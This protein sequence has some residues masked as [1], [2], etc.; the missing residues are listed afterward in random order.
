MTMKKITDATSFADLMAGSRKIKERF[1][2]R[3]ADLVD[4]A[5]LASLIEANYNKGKSRSGNPSWDGLVLF[6]MQMLKQWYRLSDRETHNLVSDRISW[7]RFVGLSL[8]DPV[9]DST[10]LCRFRKSMRTAG[11]YNRLQDMLRSQLEERHL[12]VKAGSVK[13][14]VIK[15]A[16]KPKKRKKAVKSKPEPAEPA[17]T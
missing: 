4:W 1:F 7:S 11:I 13:D 2:D 3:I 9:P 14:A 5:P 12:A 15:R 17:A 8:Q 6:K 16:H 10:L